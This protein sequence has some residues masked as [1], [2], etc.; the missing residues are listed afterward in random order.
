MARM[1][2]GGILSLV[3]F[4]LP[5]AVSANV[6]INEIAWMGTA[7]SASDEWVELYSASGADLGGWILKTEDGGMN[8]TLSGIISAGG[9]FLI[10]RTDDTTV[11]EVPADFI[12]PFGNGL[13]NSGEI[14]VLVNA[15]GAVEDRVSASEGW[16]AG[17]NTTKET[18]QLAPSSIEG[19]ITASATPKAENVSSGDSLGGSIS[20]G[21]SISEEGDSLPV[22]SGSGVP[23]VPPEL[24][25]S[26]KAYAGKDRESVAGAEVPF[27]GK[28]FGW[29]NKPLDSATT[30]FLWNFGDGT[31]QDGQNASHI[32]IYPGFY[33]ATLS[34]VSGKESASDFAT[35]AVGENPVFVSEILPVSNGW[36]EL[37]NP[38]SK[39][40][41]ISG[42][43]IK[44]GVGDR[45]V[46]PKGTSLGARSLV[47]FLAEITGV[48]FL[49]QNP[50]AILLYP[51]SKVADELSYNGLVGENSVVSDADE[52]FLA[53]PTPGAKNVK[54]SVLNNTVV[55]RQEDVQP[56]R[57]DNEIK[58]VITENVVSE[59]PEENVL[60]VDLETKKSSLLASVFDSNLF[61][62]AFSIAVGVLV[63]ALFLLFRKSFS[64]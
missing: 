11:P 41:D 57:S 18:M 53:T 3:F 5:I 35:V 12:T 58:G 23:Y 43:S 25:P 52:T 8:I 4:I 63:G 32:Y 21:G 27:E 45:F 42:W 56:P 17:D 15:S 38:S 2:S 7:N 44:N 14:L 16:P 62:L 36:I 19:W 46:F 60:E 20:V 30:R 6:V 24:L 28:A 55:K 61:W 31:L 13:S 39:N 64:K 10:E 33:V 37:S 22:S 47:V 51:N 1:K 34:V 48:E 50:K 26:I 9:Y 59:E 49:N 29:E 54:S 40:V